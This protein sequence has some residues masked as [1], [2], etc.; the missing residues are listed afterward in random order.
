[1]EG[2]IGCCVTDISATWHRS[3]LSVPGIKV[4]LFAGGIPKQ[5]QMGGGAKTDFLA[6]LAYEK[7]I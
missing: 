6:I 4:S 2:Y 3:A 7:A 1:M 5:S